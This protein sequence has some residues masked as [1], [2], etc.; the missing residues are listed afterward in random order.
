MYLVFYVIPYRPWPKIGAIDGDLRHENPDPGPDV[1][2]GVSKTR[3]FDDFW[4]KSVK[5]GLKLAG[6]RP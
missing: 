3:F 1:S 5:T 2:P 6:F 4:P